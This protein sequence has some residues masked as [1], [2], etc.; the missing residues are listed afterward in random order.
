MLLLCFLR[1][2]GE[3]VVCVCVCVLLSFCLLVFLGNG[4]GSEKPREYECEG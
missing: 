2:G 3:R 4:G 1:G